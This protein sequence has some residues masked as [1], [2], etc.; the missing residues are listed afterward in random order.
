M[1]EKYIRFAI[2]NPHFQM[3]KFRRIALVFVALLALVPK[4]QAQFS[5]EGNDPGGLL[6]SRME[7]NNF[8]L[9]YPKGLDSLARV[10]GTQLEEARTRLS[11]SSGFLIGENYKSRM[12]VVLH[13]WNVLPNASVAWA[14]K[15]MD[16]YT[17][18]DP[19]A[20]IPLSWEKELA[21]HEGRHAAQM[22]L[23]AE[24]KFKV[25][26]YLTGEMFAGAIAGLYPGPA[27]LE[28]DAV[29]AETA[30]S[31][32]GRGR[33]AS[34]LN[35][36]M[37]AFDSGDWKDY[38][39]WS[40]SSQKTFIPD[41]YKVGYL[42]ISGTRVFF[43]DPLFTKRYFQSAVRKCRFFN[44]QK[45]IK[46]AS[47]MKF[48]DA[49]QTIE[50]NWQSIWAE[51]ADARG[52]FMPGVQFSPQA[53]R[54]TFYQG[55][56]LAADGNIFTLRSGITSSMALVKMG[57]DGSTDRIRSFA[58]YSSRL[59]SDPA[60]GRIYWTESVSDKRWSLKGTSQVRY[61]ET[62]KPEKIHILASDGKY[63]NPAPSE[64]GKTISVTEYPISGGSAI[65]I[66]DSED[67]HTIKRYIAPD[68]IQFTETTWMDGHLYA[69]GIDLVG[70]GIWEI[71]GLS[72]DGKALFKTLEESQPVEV[73]TLGR[74]PGKPWLT[75]VS[76]RSGVNEM[77]ALDVTSGDLRQVTSTRYGI[78]SPVIGPS[79]DTLYYSSVAASD[80]PESYRQGSMM[81]ATAIKDLPFK[82]VK[83][84]QIHSYPVADA[85][86]RQ[87][88]EL[89]EKDTLQA[90]KVE[91]SHPRSYFK[92]QPPHIHSWSPI[93][94]NYNNVDDLSL[95]TYYESAS[96]G[97]TALFQN[98]LGTGYGFIGYSFH[99]DP[100]DE[101]KWRNSLHLN[102]IYSG[103]YPVIE[104][105][106]DYGDRVT[107]N[108]SRVYA[109]RDGKKTYFNNA[110]LNENT[111]YFSGTLKLYI[112]FNF[113]S[114][115]ISRGLIPKFKY[116]FTNDIY[117]DGIQKWKYGKRKDG[118]EGY[119]F[120]GK[121]TEGDSFYLTTMDF[122]LRGYVMH[123]TASSQV[124][125]SLGFGAEVGLHS[126]PGHSDSFKKMAYVYTYGYLPGII[127][128]QGLKLTASFETD[129]GGDKFSMGDG[130]LSTT[131][132][133][134]VGTNLRSIQN[135]NATQKLKVT[136]DYAI[137]FLPVDW[138]FLGP[139]A[140]VRNFVLTP[141]CDFAYQSYRS[142]PELNLNPEGIKNEMMMSYGADLTVHL[143]NFFWIP[144]DTEIGLRYAR[145]S[146]QNL[147]SLNGS[148]LD[149][150]YIGWIFSIDI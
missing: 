105:N 74:W 130:I 76:D 148:G 9:L 5:T 118:S 12:P 34:F 73:S 61:V 89:Q 136:A 75:F 124:F 139:V 2:V 36:M 58:S 107:E 108:I 32:S 104:I 86:T 97:A 62:S 98:L 38:W 37:P 102:Y 127:P 101:G 60:K 63:F 43:D 122:S 68:G 129:L 35:Y 44:L 140:F 27:F 51:N 42:T 54:S 33:Q 149:K 53:S 57:T 40:H 22:Q 20:P 3:T 78:S 17:V 64:D 56:T 48:K 112:P 50:E 26:H 6:W 90:T 100:L 49:Y 134:L 132:R 52:P 91:F 28:G 103:F 99:E 88:M 123:K 94:F 23:G 114:G 141:F 59:V 145:N 138:S 142:L 15:R 41:H 121:I 106:A 83:F 93:Y 82:E 66:L 18:L 47:G 87:E 72:P 125:P 39:K 79:A 109:E 117:D 65:R 21:I 126:R 133:G 113:S 137:P 46:E 84:S 81:Y 30:L 120:D 29:V 147:G 92:F 131:P 77:Y 67:G 116:K 4:A 146:W 128:Q 119:I 25:M 115:G 144:Y 71:A 80:N 95:D 19:Y 8:S 150:N 85:L 10:Y 111:N 143:G 96:I 16:I 7:T 13:A 55:S 31:E 45:T 69:I 11:L 110:S 14:P 135:K 24:G 70:S 1:Y